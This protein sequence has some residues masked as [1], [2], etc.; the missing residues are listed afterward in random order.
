MALVSV[1]IPYYRKINHIKKTLNSVFKQTFQD[2]EIILIYDDELKNDLK[3]IETLVKNNAKV[4]IIDNLNNIGAGASRNTGIKNSSGSVIAFL[5]S[6]DY[7]E[8]DRLEKQLKFMQ[9]NEYNFTFCNYRKKNKHKIIDVVSEKDKI[10]YFDLLTDCNIGLSTVF[11]KRNLVDENLF[12]TLKTK[13]D[14]VAWLKIT[15]KN[16]F[17]HNYP[18]FLVEWSYS[19]NSLSS[20]FFQ[21]IFDSFRVYYTFLNFNIFKSLYYVT[22]LSINSIKRKI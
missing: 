1:I 19:E 16:E 11:V 5:D 2:F 10:S 20:N 21:K 4:K 3:V 6:D 12:P 17:A 13:E 8:P 15:K 9:D 22:L 14:F 18:E 7:W